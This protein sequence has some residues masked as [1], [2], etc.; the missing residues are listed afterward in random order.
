MSFIVLNHWKL[1]PCLL[2]HS[3]SA[4]VVFDATVIVK[5]VPWFNVQ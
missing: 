5:L 2:I 1:S 4:F 3:D